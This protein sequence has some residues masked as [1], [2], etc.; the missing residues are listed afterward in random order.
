[1]GEGFKIQRESASSNL[2]LYKLGD[3]RSVVSGGWAIDSTY[4][5]GNTLTKNADNMT[6]YSPAVTNGAYI[7][8]K[9][10]TPI[11]LTNYKT[12]K[13]KAI[14]TLTSVNAN[15]GLMVVV[16]ASWATRVASDMVSNQVISAQEH[17]FIID[18]SSINSSNQVLVM[19][20]GHTGM[21]ATM[22]VKE[23]WLEE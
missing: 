1:M 7:I 23:V 19:A 5:S 20:N 17:T 16:G 12:L 8:V 15:G 9:N 18:I 10:A 13:V 4:A 14:L 6:I 2:Y 3:E 21:A 11:D 22:V